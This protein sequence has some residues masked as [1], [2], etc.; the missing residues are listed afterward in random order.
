MTNIAR[1]WQQADAVHEQWSDLDRDRWTDPTLPE[2]AKTAEAT[3]SYWKVI[4]VS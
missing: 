2:A 4:C 3:R 1:G